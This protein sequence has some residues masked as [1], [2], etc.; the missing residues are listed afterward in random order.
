[1]Q[2]HVLASG[3]TGNGVFIEI[4]ERRFL[5]DAG[6]SARRIER[7]L[8]EIGV[9]L[10]SLDGIFITHEHNDHISG[11]PVL[12]KRHHLPVYTRPATWDVITSV[13][14]IPPECRRDLGESINFGPVKVI[15]FPVSHD[16][17]DPIGFCF[18]YANWKWVLATDLGVITR[19]AA[20]ALAYAD[21]A[22]IESNH[23]VEM[24]ANGPYPAFLK[25]R[26]RGKQG[27]LS[28]QDAGQILARIPRVKK[29]QVFLAHLSQ[30]NNH[31]QVAEQTVTEILTNHNCLVGESIVLHRTYPDR[32]ASLII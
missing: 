2:L 15:P 19:G 6:I 14:R 27:H 9:S 25:K 22:V 4:G 1:M 23:D 16:A 3:S 21:V 7:G 18:C 13:T 32:T 24:L 30:H 31:P 17:V 26:I 5:I 28:N 11:L 12:A 29:M 8:A 20:Q 10:A